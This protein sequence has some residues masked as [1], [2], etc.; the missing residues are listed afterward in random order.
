VI[1]GACQGTIRFTYS[2]TYSGTTLDGKPA[3][4]VDYTETDSL[5]STSPSF[6]S[7]LYGNDGSKVSKIYYDP[8][9]LLPITSGGNP[10][11]VVYS[12]QQSTPTSVTAG[13]TGTLFTY[14]DYA[15]TASAVTKGPLIWTVARDTASTL[16]FTRTDDAQNASSGALEYTSS[17]TYRINANNTLTNLY[18]VIK[19]PNTFT[20]G[21]GDLSITETYQQ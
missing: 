18:K 7:K 11:G 1:S 3:A 16:L 4:I 12:N 6:C 14:I 17:K 8:T 19:T 20:G 9:T 15:G 2:P 13:S 10:Q 5:A 21:L